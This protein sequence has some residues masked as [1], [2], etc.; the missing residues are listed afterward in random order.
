MHISELP[1]W[2]IRI[3]FVETGYRTCMTATECIRS[4]FKIHNET[5]NIW[6]HFPICL[7]FV[8]YCGYLMSTLPTSKYPLDTAIVYISVFF[9]NFCT[10]FMSGMCHTFYCMSNKVHDICWFMDFVGIL[11]GILGGGIGICYFTFY[12]HTTILLFYLFIFLL[13]YPILIYTTFKKY[14]KHL[15]CLPMT[16]DDGFPEFCGPLILFNFVSWISIII[17]SKAMLPEYSTVDIYKKAW[18]LETSCPIILCVGT[19]MQ[20]THFP[21]KYLTA[22]T[23]D[24]VGHSHQFWHLCSLILMWVWIHA[25]TTHYEARITYAWPLSAASP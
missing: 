16:P 24:I 10:L 19:V 23:C 6:L 3:P 8:P 18:I 15:S 21:E 14:K 4:L 9:G 25:I 22:G 11:T 1:S 2:Y 12:S 7:A 17:V 20:L 13:L 5:V